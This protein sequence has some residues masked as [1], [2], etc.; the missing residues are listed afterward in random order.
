MIELWGLYKINERK[1]IRSVMFH[2]GPQE[3]LFKTLL[4]FKPPSTR[5]LFVLFWTFAL[6]MISNSFKIFMVN[7]VSL[8]QVYF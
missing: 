4:M 5:E 8:K 3:P 6:E 2:L 1:G 7:Y